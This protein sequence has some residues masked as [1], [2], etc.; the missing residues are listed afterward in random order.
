MRKLI[1]LFSI[2][3]LVG[4]L[5]ACQDDGPYDLVL[6]EGQ[7]VYN[8]M[9]EEIGSIDEVFVDEGGN[10]LA[11]VTVGDFLGLGDKQ[12]FISE[13]KL[14][15]RPKGGFYLN[16]STEQLALVPEY[17]DD[18]ESVRPGIVPTASD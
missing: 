4:S 5:A 12:V 9:D 18:N 15:A 1:A 8:S 7:T 17:Q 11:V 16:L 10:Q 14:S 6:K 2:L 3:A 13:T